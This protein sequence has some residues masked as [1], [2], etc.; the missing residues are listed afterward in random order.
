M[1]V[2]ELYEL[3]KAHGVENRELFLQVNHDDDTW[4]MTPGYSTDAT[5]IEVKIDSSRSVIKAT[6]KRA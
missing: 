5:L 6:V 1:T 4:I 2:K 3:A